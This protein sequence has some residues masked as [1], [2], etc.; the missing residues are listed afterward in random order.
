MI[1]LAAVVQGCKAMQAAEDDQT[2]VLG[3]FVDALVAGIAIANSAN[4]AQGSVEQ[5][6]RKCELEYSNGNWTLVYIRYVYRLKTN[7][8]NLFFALKIPST[9]R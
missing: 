6:D 5:Y 4:A 8:N 3:T 2:D 7:N 1:V 9:S